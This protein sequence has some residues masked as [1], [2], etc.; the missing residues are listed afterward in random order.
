[1]DSNVPER[2][3]SAVKARLRCRYELPLVLPTAQEHYAQRGSD[4]FW[5]EDISMDSGFDI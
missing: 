4:L 2:L 3:L 5:A 1:M